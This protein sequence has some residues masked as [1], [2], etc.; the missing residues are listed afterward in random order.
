MDCKATHAVPT[1]MSKW[2][3]PLII[4]AG[5]VSAQVCAD[6][7]AQQLIEKMSSSAKSQDFK[8]YFTFERGRQ[9][10]SYFVAHK[11]IDDKQ[12]QRL[13]FMD[14]PELEIIKDGHSFQCL[15]PG[16]KNFHGAHGQLSAVANIG[17]PKS[18]LW[19]FYTAEILGD[20]RVAGRETTRVLLKPQDQHRY[21]F[22]FNVDKD[23]GLMVK[24]IVLDGRGAPMERFHFVNLD[25]T[26]VS[27][28]DL[29]PALKD[30]RVVEHTPVPV[31]DAAGD[32]D[33][34]QWQ[35]A[36]VPGGFEQEVTD[37]KPWNSKR[38]N[39]AFM[40][41]DGLSAFSVFIE[42]SSSENQ[43]SI[44]KQLGST[45][46]LSHYLSADGKV[47]LITVVGEVPLMT[48]KNIASAVRFKP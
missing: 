13:V 2:I 37:M 3:K 15:H 43:A 35:L 48:A 46:A 18:Q 14:G 10:T 38:E 34:S 4:A 32:V 28:A 26:N 17:K 31:A 20:Q 12:H 24:M 41:S 30:Y 8:G 39:K 33:A 11:V 27:D 16:D 1:R 40:Y 42:E 7:Q 5:L 23:T 47:Y 6:E 36:W 44:S 25:V 22:V 9:S 29:Q 21:P 19:N 45:V